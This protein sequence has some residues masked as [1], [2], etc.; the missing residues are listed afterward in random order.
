MKK[1]LKSTLLITALS[2]SLMAEVQFD[3]GAQQFS[4]SVLGNYKGSTYDLEKSIASTGLAYIDGGY[5][6]K[7]GRA[8]SVKA[9]VKEPKPHWGVSFAMYCYIFDDGCGVNLVG[10]NGNAINIHLD[11]NYLRVN[12]IEV[13]GHRN[14][15]VNEFYTQTTVD[16]VVNGNDDNISVVVN[17]HQF[18]FLMP[19]FKLA[20]VELNVASDGGN[21]EEKYIDSINGL[22][23]TG[24]D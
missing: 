15:A 2:S 4:N 19:N 1:I 16:G 11:K 18:S 8:G 7:N 21:N 14:G 10:S 12:G 24:S 5:K 13:D 6:P 23:I 17:G 9:Q 22:V 3:L 20:H